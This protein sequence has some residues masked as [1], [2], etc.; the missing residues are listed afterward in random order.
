M[1][2]VEGL[3]AVSPA[4]WGVSYLRE[5]IENKKACP[6]SSLARPGWEGG[7]QVIK[8]P[9]PNPKPSFFAHARLR[10][11]SSISQFVLAA[12]LEALGSKASEV[13]A[14]KIRLGIVV[15]VFSGCV[16]YSRR[17]YD[18]TLREPETASPLVFPETVFNAPAS[19]L[20]SY[21][22]GASI[23]YTIVGDPGTFLLGLALG[24]DWLADDKVDACLVI[25]AEEM[26]WLTGDAFR[27]FS[28]QARVSEGAGALLLTKNEEAGIFLEAVSNPQLF[29][30]PGDRLD[31]AQRVKQ[32]IYPLVRDPDRAVLWDGL[33]NSSLLDREEKKAWA[34]WPGEKISI[35]PI[36]GEGLSAATA[37][38]CVAAVDYLRRQKETSECLV[39]IVGCNQ[40][41]VAGLF[42]SRPLSE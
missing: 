38:Q 15:A 9:A 41:A 8:V 1:I 35:K 25:G 30:K 36:L 29:T 33:Q 11:S 40:Q 28:K 22:G 14:G 27:L 13:S 19:H 7:L 37:W 17:F 10:R 24:A 3:G 23:Y 4:G 20:A 2:F 32:E 18:E 6:S 5:A 31:A 16:N 34:T 42:S 39:N 12:G 21:L 26:D